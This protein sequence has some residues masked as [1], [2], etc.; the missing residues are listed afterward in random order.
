MRPHWSITGACSVSASSDQAC[1]A[2]LGARRA[3]G[4][5]HRIFGRRPAAAPFPPPTPNRPAAARPASAWGCADGASPAIGLSCS[6]LSATI[7][8]GIIGGVMAIL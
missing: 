6:S 4:N 5:D 3:A 7:T 8:T 1:H 2:L